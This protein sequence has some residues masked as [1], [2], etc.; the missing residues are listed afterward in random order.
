MHRYL[1]EPLI[2]NKLLELDEFAQKIPGVVIVHD[3]RDGSVA[4]M[5]PRGTELLGV[6]L[7][8]ITSIQ[9]AEY[10]ALYFNE[11]DAA[12]YVPKILGLLQENN[13]SNF[14]TFFQQVKH[15]GALDWTWYMSS[16]KVFLRDSNNVPLLTLT[17]AM[18]I[19]AMHHM[20][21]K[22]EKLLEE[23][24]FLKKNYQCFD[25]LTIRE[26]EVL[27]YVA[28]GLSSN[29]IAGKLFISEFTVTTHKR[30]IKS[31][32]NTNSTADLIKYARAFDLI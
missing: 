2:Y 14:C 27:K 5:S 7:E 26:R 29:E 28:L 32:L 10:Y 15:K 30:N 4:W 8:E 6:T 16:V 1:S 31:K 20:I 13:D 12:D 18:P 21:Q 23:N 17:I 19:D 24:N 22:A 3:L 11:Q 25:A 9:S